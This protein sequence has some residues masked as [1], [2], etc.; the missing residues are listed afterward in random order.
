MRGRDYLDDLNAVGMIIV[1]WI[2]ERWDRGY[3]AWMH[4]SQNSRR[5]RALVDM[6]INLR[7]P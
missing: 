3:M 4:V 7:V 5:W 6:G 2:F 1:K